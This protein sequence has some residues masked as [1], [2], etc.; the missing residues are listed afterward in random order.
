[1]SRQRDLLTTRH[2]LFTNIPPQLLLIP[3]L[4][5]VNLCYNDIDKID[6][7]SP[8]KPTD[9]GL[10][11]GTGFMITIF[12]R[13]DRAQK[14]ILERLRSLNLSYNKLTVAGLTGLAGKGALGLRVLNLGHNKLTGVLEAEP[15]GLD[16]KRLPE[17]AS[18][19]LAGNPHLNNLQGDVAPSAAIDT[20]GCAWG[21]TGG[22][23]TS[24]GAS[25]R[26]S[27]QSTPEAS[28]AAATYTPTPGGPDDVPSPTLTVPFITHAAAT[29]DSEPLTLEMDVYLP[30]NADKPCP[31]VVW[32]HGGGL[33]Q[34]NKENLPPHLRRL[35]S[36]DTKGEHFIVIAPNYR[37][38]PQAAICDILADAD[39]AVAY[40]R[41]KLNDKVTAAGHKVQ[42]DPSRVILSG[43]SAGG[44]LALMAGLP[45]PQSIP[46]ADVGGHR[47]PAGYTPLAIAPFYPITDLQHAFWSTETNPVPWWGKSVP[48]SAARPHL[49]HRDPPVGFAVSGGPRSILYPYMLQHGLFPNLLFY[50]QRSRGVGLDSYRPSPETMSIT[51]RLKYLAEKDTPRPP[52]YMV[53]GTIDDKI[54]PLEETVDLLKCTSGGEVVEVIEGADHAFDENPA[55]QCQG[56]YR[57]LESVL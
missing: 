6:I 2:N 56:F 53:Y 42:V 13:Q 18:L 12:E 28:A 14:V 3:D 37:L 43:G 55:E 25:P 48:D 32:W 24:L 38:A 39:A 5:S 45:V 15:A 11:Y 26:K 49:N 29:F 50:N 4:E 30:P 21:E 57:W 51:T 10:A 40:A 41:T 33:L 54:Q 31:V 27:R 23:A 8:V 1:M 19:I 46:D 17:L 36:R 20:E 16:M 7:T 44:Y 47:G 22:A 52:I 34:G 9:E 35:P